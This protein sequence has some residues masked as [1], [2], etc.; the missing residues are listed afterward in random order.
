[1][2]RGAI[3]RPH[4]DNARGV[5]FVELSD[6]CHEATQRPGVLAHNPFDSKVP[7]N[8][9]FNVSTVPCNAPLYSYQTFGGKV[10][11]RL[12]SSQLPNA[13]EVS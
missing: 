6:L 5:A 11:F 7:C 12:Y 4:N 8:I 2:P 3:L 10:L 9:P 1:M 13:V